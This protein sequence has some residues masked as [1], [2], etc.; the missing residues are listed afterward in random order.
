MPA[1][2]SKASARGSPPGRASPR[3]QSRTHGRRSTS[4][5]P[6]S[7][8]PSCP[9]RLEELQSGRIAESRAQIVARETVSLDRLDR[10]RIDEE[11]AP[12][13]ES[14]GD[15]QVEAEVRKGQL[16]LDPH[17]FM[18]RIAKAVTTAG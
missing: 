13:L 15:R 17:G 3:A 7:W 12:R 10:R 1:C 6:A 11:L 5:G 2:C 4:A 9:R 16:Q 8:S 18:D 14:L